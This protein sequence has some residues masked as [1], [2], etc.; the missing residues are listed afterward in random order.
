LLGNYHGAVGEHDGAVA[1]GVEETHLVGIGQYLHQAMRVLGHL[2][3][4]RGVDHV[5][6]DA[7]VGHFRAVVF[8]IGQRTVHRR[9]MLGERGEER[10]QRRH[11]HGRVVVVV[12]L[13]PLGLRVVPLQEGLGLARGDGGV[14]H[15]QVVTH[16]ESP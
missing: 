11:R 8:L 1:A 4:E 3:I 6:A 10:L 13:V 5:L 12:R 9:V 7:V 16:R 14:E 15:H 2:V